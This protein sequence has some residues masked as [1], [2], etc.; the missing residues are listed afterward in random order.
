MTTEHKILASMH[1]GPHHSLCT[2]AEIHNIIGA[3]AFEGL[4]KLMGAGM[5]ERVDGLLFPT[6]AGVARL[7]ELDEQ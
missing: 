1:L 5:I 7:V 4:V 2:A 3:G 6:E